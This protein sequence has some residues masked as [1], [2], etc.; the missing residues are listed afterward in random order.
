MPSGSIS[1]TF[2]GT[3]TALTMEEEFGNILSSKIGPLLSE[4]GKTWDFVSIENALDMSTGH[5]RFT[6]HGIDERTVSNVFNLAETH[7][8]KILTALNSFRR[9]TTPGRRWIYHSTDTYIVGVALRMLL[10]KWT[11]NDDLVNYMNTK[12]FGPLQLSQMAQHS[13]RVT[14][15][16]Y[17]QPYTT[18]GMFLTRK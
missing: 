2:F 4:A 16:D 6:G 11:Q 10:Q 3:L 17:K 18:T 8:T 13:I 7:S 5:Y 15:D 14:Y 12:V 1:K 9:R